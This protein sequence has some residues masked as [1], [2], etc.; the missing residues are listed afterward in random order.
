[1]VSYNELYLC[2]KQFSVLFVE[3][4]LG[5]QKETAEIFK[6]LFKK[7]DIC[8]NGL[9]AILQYERFHKENQKHYDIVITDINLPKMNGIELTKT[10]YAKNKEQ[11]I[12][13]IS[14]HSETSYLLDLINL[15]IEQF[16]TKPI[17]YDKT[18]STLYQA[19]D[20][21]RSI[22][23]NQTQ[24]EN[25]SKIISFDNFTWDTQN[26]LL[27]HDTTQVH[28]TQKETIFFS[29]LVKNKM[30]PTTFEEIYSSLW[31]DNIEDANKKTLLPLVS[32]LRQK[33]PKDLIKNQYSV[34]Y[35]LNY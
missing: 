13:V 17:E 30:K 18:L 32:R 3:D 19:C 10:I 21:L 28:L 33:L 12:I 23:V 8:D 25:N 34:G 6:V 29:L 4:D 11:T 1:M 26:K 24:E 15:G 22:Q 2:T 16:L 7:V 20:K 5:F 14:A 9:E 31:N 27:F 35:T